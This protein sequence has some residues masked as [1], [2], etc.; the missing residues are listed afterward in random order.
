MKGL[1]EKIILSAEGITKYFGGLAALSDVGF[2]LYEGEILGL[3]GPNGSG[4]TT[5]FN[6]IVGVYKPNK[7]LVS[8]NG[9][10]IQGLRPDVICKKGIA[11]TF[12]IPKPFLGMS[13]LENVMVGTSFGHHKMVSLKSSHKE[14]E[15]ILKLVGLEK[16]RHILA[17][18][19][20]LVERKILE[21]ARSLATNPKILLLDEVIAGLNP[22]EAMQMSNLIKKI[23]KT[24]ITI[25]MIEH[26]MKAIMGISDRIIA[27]SY[28]KKIAEGM[29]EE[30]VL[31]KNVI[32]A[33]LGG[34]LNARP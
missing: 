1:Q 11:R 5:L 27:I 28:G 10:Y 31:D 23:N 3:I 14:S 24:G 17:S 30:V 9:E 29:P 21:L 13:V 2:Y 6:V 7:G 15:K 22:T 26:V 4:K 19:L 34:T 25:L 32:E 8:F 20:N 18:Q 33:Y 12:Q 16:K